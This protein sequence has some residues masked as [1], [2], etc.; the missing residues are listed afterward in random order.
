VSVANDPADYNNVAAVVE[1]FAALGLVFTATRHID[2]SVTLS[3]F[4]FPDAAEN[5][6]QID[7]LW[8]RCLPDAPDKEAAI[9]QYVINHPREKTTGA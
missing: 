7:A 3:R 4:K 1:R 5:E 6:T 2:G 8:A 9:A